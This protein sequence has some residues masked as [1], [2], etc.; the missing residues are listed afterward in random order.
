MANGVSGV[1]KVS[2]TPFCSCSAS[3]AAF[4]GSAYS[5]S[6]GKPTWLQNSRARS[7]VPMPTVSS[8]ARDVLLAEHSSERA[9]QHDDGALIRAPLLGEAHSLARGGSQNRDRRERRVRVEA[10]R[11]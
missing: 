2:T 7:G 1:K 4:S 3:Y 9:H 8:F 11:R 5:A 6:A 10:R